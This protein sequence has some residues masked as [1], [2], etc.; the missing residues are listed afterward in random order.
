M[1][2]LE[3]GAELQGDFNDITGIKLDPDLTLAPMW[4]DNDLSLQGAV[5]G[6]A[7]FDHVVD[8]LDFG[9][10]VGSFG[11]STASFTGW[12]SGDFDLSGVIDIEDFS[13]Y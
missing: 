5:P 7:N 9:F 2:L 13:G 10:L 11:D 1:L 12:S 6:D 8:I 3:D 4:S